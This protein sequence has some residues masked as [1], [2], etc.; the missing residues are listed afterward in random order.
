M[1]PTT[2]PVCHFGR[3]APDLD[4]AASGGGRA[5]LV[6]ASGAGERTVGIDAIG[7]PIPKEEQ[8]T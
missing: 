5:S 6:H 4:P 1:A 3:A 2:L 7:G 8:L